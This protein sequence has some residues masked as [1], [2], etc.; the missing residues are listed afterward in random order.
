MD[1][2]TVIIVAAVIVAVAIVAVGFMAFNNGGGSGS[3]E[4]DGR[5][6]TIDTELRVFG[7]ANNDKYLN[8]KDVTFIKD[9][10][11]GKSAWNSAENPLADVN[12][13]GKITSKD[14]EMV[15]DYIDGKNGTMYYVD[16][17]NQRSSVDYPLTRVLDNGTY[18]IHSMM[19]TGL[20]WMII[21]GLYDNVT[22]MSNGDIGPDDLD[23][24]LYPNADKMKVFKDIRLT[25]DHYETFINEKI[26]ISMG[27]K[28]W[29]DE[30][31]LK[32]V[33]DN[34]GK[35]NLNI[36][37]LPMNRTVDGIT[38]EDTMITLGAMCNL[39]DKTS[40]YIKYTEKVDAAID[41]AIA[42][43]DVGTKTYMMPYTAP[44]YDLNPMYVDAH[45]TGSVLMA[46]VYTIEKLPLSSAV[47]VVTAD[48]FDAV[49][50]ETII[51]YNPNVL[52][53]SSFG[54]ASS[55]T[56][57]QEQYIEHFE[58][59]A[60]IFDSMGYTGEIYGI[61]FENCT[62]AGSAFL[63]TL[64]SMVWEDAFSESEAWALMYEYY[65]NFTNYK[66]TL[67][68]LKDSKFAVWEYSYLDY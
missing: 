2:K 53:I 13:D 4:D 20:D 1:Q 29:Y 36:I 23:L 47:S 49:E 42:D 40:A 17:N 65:H 8:D 61:A 19:S 24:E 25:S 21:L 7:N 38:W 10:V 18:G 28:R 33:E 43:A 44:G 62:M 27:D 68:D 66:G 32:A 9:I 67:D 15:Q 46:D 60:E 37:K 3:S 30:S 55:K 59:I 31:F 6:Y 51:K 12:A 34:Y 11:N 56:M 35:Y 5:T 22:Y 52:I 48:G 50:A 58:D 54:Y 45:G 63:L 26:K 14:Y 64:A 16:W 57:T 39:Q 41:K